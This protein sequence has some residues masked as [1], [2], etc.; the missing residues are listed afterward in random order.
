MLEPSEHDTGVAEVKDE[1]EKVAS[2][3]WI[4]GKCTGKCSVFNFGV[5]ARSI[6]D[7][8]RKTTKSCYFYGPP[9]QQLKIKTKYIKCFLNILK[10]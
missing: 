1:C 7:L 9:Q 4:T 5:L 8:G 3:T 2:Q 6:I 10:N